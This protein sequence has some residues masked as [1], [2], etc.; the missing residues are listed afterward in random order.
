MY[1]IDTT[2][3]NVIRDYDLE[4]VSPVSDANDPKFLEY[5][6][7]IEL[8]NTPGEISENPIIEVRRHVWESIKTERERRKYA[9]VKVNG[10]WFHSDPDSRTQQIGLVIAGVSIPP[11]LMWKTLTPGGGLFAPVEVEMTPTLAQAIFIGTIYHDG[12][13]YAAG[14]I[15]RAA[16]LASTDP[17]TYDY[18]TNWPESFEDIVANQ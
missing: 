8:G 4:V 15:H 1:T 16:I 17:Y 14:E 12:A 10:H 5:K 6:A 9:G 2:T 11:G 18:T 13:F 7:W 3:G